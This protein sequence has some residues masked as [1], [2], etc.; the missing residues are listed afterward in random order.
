MLCSA[1]SQELFGSAV[2]PWHGK[3]ARP[4]EWLSMGML[5]IFS[6]INKE[7][8]RS[9]SSPV[10]DITFYICKLIKTASMIGI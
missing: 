8:S 9:A 5:M 3:M 1:I 4:G 6:V 2:E 10:V 7:T